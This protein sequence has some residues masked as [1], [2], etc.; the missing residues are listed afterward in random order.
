MKLNETGATTSA[1]SLPCPLTDN[2]DALICELKVLMDKGIWARGHLDNQRYH[3]L[4]LKLRGVL[5]N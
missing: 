1:P 2:T 5:E 4:K 3:E